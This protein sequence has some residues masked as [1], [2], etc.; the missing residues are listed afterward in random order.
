MS[1][2]TV[3]RESGATGM[4][5]AGS[6]ARAAIEAD[7]LSRAVPGRMAMKEILRLAA[8]LSPRSS[9]SVRRSISEAQKLAR[10][11]K[12]KSSP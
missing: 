1:E 7:H 4:Q 3:M 10:E 8:S 2:T 11:W 6:E 12:P 9:L 5:K